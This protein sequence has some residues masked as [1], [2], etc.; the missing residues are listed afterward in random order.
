MSFHRQDRCGKS[1]II[2]CPFA[3]A[4]QLVY[5]GESL[6]LSTSS[7]SLYLAS[8]QGIANAMLDQPAPMSLVPEAGRGWLQS[9]GIEASADDRPA[10][11]MCWSLL[12][13]KDTAFGW[14][15][16]L[17]DSIAGL[18][19]ILEIALLE[20]GL[21][22]QKLQLIN[23]QAGPVTVQRL[24]CT[25][26]I[27][28]QCTELLGFYGRWCQEFQQQRIDWQ[29]TWLQENRNG[30]N[31]HGN[32]PGV[33]VGSAGFSEQLGQV[34]G[35]HLAWSGNHRLRADY[36][37]EGHR[38][39]QAEVLYLPGEVV[40]AQ[41]ES[42]RSAE[43]LVAHSANGLNEMS[44]YF[45]QE[46]RQRTNLTKPRPVHL[47]TWEAFYFDHDITELKKLAKAASEVGVER[48]ILDDGWFKGRN[49]DTSA[50]GD[51]FVD[52]QKYP[53]GLMPIIDY[54]KSLGMEFGLWFEP[55]MINP[56][57][58]LYRAR[59]DWVLALPQ[60]DDVLARNQLVLNLANADAYA[61]IKSRLWSL[62][63]EY[64]ID[65]VKWD[66]NRDYCQSSGSIAPQALAQVDALYR[67]LDEINQAFPNMEIESCSSGGARV[68]FGILNYTKRFWA[69]DCNDAL[70]RQSIQR[71]FSYFFPPEVMGA[72]IGPTKSHTTNRI[73]DDTFRAGTALFGHLGI[74]W[75]LLEVSG[76]Q[77]ADISQWIQHYK[78]YRHILHRGK[79]WRLPSADGRAQTQWALSHDGLQGV[80]LYCQ[81]TMPKQ[82]QTLKVCLPGLLAEQNYQIKIVANSPLPAHLM[83]ALPPW[84]QEGVTLNGASLALHGLQMP[85]MDPESLLLLSVTAVP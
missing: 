84:W 10:W 55:E 70:E 36:T 81:L 41:G 27:E 18:K 69:S 49:D 35:A 65:Y 14:S 20:S 85:I 59:P 63:E 39:L 11:A 21:F 37:I 56:D 48:Y 45:H 33:I 8:Q 61:Y 28:S 15:I 40:L 19:L 68:D 4:P 5:F 25:M 16:A 66:M 46:A 47:N 24:A 74:E 38:F 80:A 54:V 51:W 58:D 60:Y 7:E 3:G 43:L 78:N 34:Y 73:H 62:F 75:N 31:S 83:K 57:S 44:Q 67:L 50:L 17:Q 32:F 72:H 12:D 76:Q 13:I 64:P 23:L 52:K 30:R 9:P 26:P 29:A 71:G 79:Q 82:A 1:L 42:I 6:P 22:S 53:H 77:K 2:A